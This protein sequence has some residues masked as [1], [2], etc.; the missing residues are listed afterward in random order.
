MD[1]DSGVSKDER[2]AVLLAAL[3]DKTKVAESTATTAGEGDGKMFDKIAADK[4]LELPLRRIRQLEITSEPRSIQPLRSLSDNQYSTNLAGYQPTWRDTNGLVVSFDFGKP[5]DLAC[6]RLVSIHKQNGGPGDPIWGLPEN[7]PWRFHV[8]PGVEQRQLR[9][10]HP[11]D[12]SSQ[13]RVEETT[14]YPTWHYSLG[15]LPTWRVDIGQNARYVRLM[16]RATTRQHPSLSLSELEVYAADKAAESTRGPSPRMSTATGRTSLVVGTSNKQVA[17]Y[18]ADGRQRWSHKLTGDVFNMVCGDLD[19]SG[20]SVA[21]VYETHGEIMH[22]YNGDGT[23]RAPGDIY[24]ALMARNHAD[25]SGGLVAMAIWGPDGPDKKEIMGW[26]EA[27]FRVMHDGTAKGLKSG[28][29]R[30]AGELH[31]FYRNEPVALATI[32]GFLDIWS[33]KRDADGNYLKLCSRLPS[34]PCG[35]PL[36]GG[37]GWIQQVAFDGHKGLLAANDGGLDYFPVEALALGGNTGLP[38]QIRP[39]VKGQW[40]FLTGG[41]PIVAAAYDDRMHVETQARIFLAR[42]DGFVNVF[43]LDGKQIALLNTGEPILGMVVL[44]RAFIPDQNRSDRPPA[45]VPARRLA[46]VTKYGVHVFDGDLNKQGAGDQVHRLRRPGR[47]GQEPRLL[48]G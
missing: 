11:Q 23:E 41:V 37:F 19:N 14:L 10:G 25:N 1:A 22:R 18:D 44:D 5:T 48:R 16:P 47:A 36:V 45:A 40:N 4:P 43:D 27:C 6:M 42:E 7:A 33:A 34:G 28:Q 35:G 26:S 31:N 39:P 32:G 29:P 2:L 46:V 9:Q 20:K 21:C 3:W 15:R 38:D 17:V 13:R 24:K 8:Q 30:G 12:R